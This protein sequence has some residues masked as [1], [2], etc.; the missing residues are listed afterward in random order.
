MTRINVHIERLVLDGLALDARGAEALRQSI[1]GT[2]LELAGGGIEP[3]DRSA[4]DST[5]PRDAARS[6]HSGAARLGRETALAI[7]RTVT[8]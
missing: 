1:A 4:I 7:H 3:G 2:L 8:R 6:T 5:L